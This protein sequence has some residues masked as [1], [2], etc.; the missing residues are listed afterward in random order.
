MTTMTDTAART[1]VLQ[2]LAEAH[3]RFC[4]LEQIYVAEGRVAE[5]EG[6]RQY[7]R[8]IRRALDAEMVDPPVAHKA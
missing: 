6:C 8:W 1:A 7:V 2:R 4:E 5:A 3:E